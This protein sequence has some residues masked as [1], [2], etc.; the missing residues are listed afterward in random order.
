MKECHNPF[1]CLHHAAVFASQ[2]LKG[3]NNDQAFKKPLPLKTDCTVRDS[4][5]IL[6][7]AD[8]MRAI[9]FTDESMFLCSFVA[10]V[11]CLHRDKKEND[12]PW[13]PQWR[14]IGIM[15]YTLSVF[16]DTT[17]CSLM[18]GDTR[19][20]AL[21]TWEKDVTEEVGRGRS[22]AIALTRAIASI[23]RS[24]NAIPL[25]MCNEDQYVRKLTDVSHGMYKCHNRYLD[26][27]DSKGEWSSNREEEEK[28]EEEVEN[29][30]Q[31]DYLVL[32]SIV[33]KA[34]QEHLSSK[35]PLDDIPVTVTPQL[36]HYHKDFDDILK[37]EV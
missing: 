4:L 29:K 26:G 34:S 37:V 5:N 19:K 12:F 17:I 13:T 8:C 2:G 30:G 10:R 18:E 25:S 15:A 9:H 27:T 6:G 23:S 28:V 3:G 22:D 20:A 33:N 35:G 11:C 24:N 36:H 21:E 14:V 31:D 16:I 1:L 32:N 7:R